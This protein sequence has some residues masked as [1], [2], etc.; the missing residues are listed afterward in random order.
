[1][2][3]P[4]GPAGAA[5]AGGGEYTRISL[6]RL[7]AAKERFEDAVVQVRLALEYRTASNFRIPQ[8]LIQLTGTDWS[9]TLT[10][11]DPPLLT[12]TDPP[13]SPQIP[14]D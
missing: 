10:R 13:K 14:T 8:A 1:M 4:G 5:T 3:L 6:A 2:L 11:F 9:S 12:K 7:L